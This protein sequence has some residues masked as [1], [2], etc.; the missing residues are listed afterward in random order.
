VS[1]SQEVVLFKGGKALDVFTSGRHTLDTPN[2][3]LLNSIVNLPFGGR[4]PFTAEIW[5]VNKVHSLD[6]KW[7]TNTPIQLRDSKYGVF[8]PVRAHGQ[9]GIKV[10]DSKKFLIKLVGTLPAFDKSNLIKYFRGLYLTKVKDTLS[11]Y[12]VNKQISVLEI[13]AYLDELSGFMRERIMPTL[14]EYGIELLNFYINDISIPEDDT[15]V[16]T[17]KDALA[18][19]AQMD[20]VGFNYVQERS[21]NTLEGAA[22]NSHGGSDLMGAGIGLGMGLGI[23]GPLGQQ[24]GGLAQVINTSAQTK[25]CPHCKASIPQEKRFCSDCGFDTAAKPQSDAVTCSSCHENY[26]IGTKFCPECGNAYNGCPNCKADVAKGALQCPA[27]GAKMP[28][29]CPGCGK[30]VENTNARF[31]PEC[32]FVLVKKCTAC[33]S[34]LAGS[35]KFCPECGAKTGQ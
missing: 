28:F 2:I 32:G 23:G 30:P 6:I 16:K 35:H 1:E 20:I 25:T 7:G 9:F 26:R 15:A 4:S 22:T 21:F 11:S 34:D 14:E 29:N 10:D 8:L 5:Y 33:G 31:C 3:P 12:L 24:A 27:C 19:R 13:N 18:K 17:L